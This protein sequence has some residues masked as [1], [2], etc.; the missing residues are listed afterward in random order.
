MLDFAGL[1]ME[2]LANRRWK[3]DMKNKLNRTIT[4]TSKD[5]NSPLHGLQMSLSHLKQDAMKENSNLSETQKDFLET[6]ESCFGAMTKITM[7]AF[8]E[9]SAHVEMETKR[10]TCPESTCSGPYRC[11][12]RELFDQAYEVGCFLLFWECRGFCLVQNLCDY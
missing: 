6:A 2:I 8:S 5:L 7:D 9:I 10:L 3:V 12:I 4:C 1:A 11:C